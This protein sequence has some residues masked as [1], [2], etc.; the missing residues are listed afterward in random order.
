MQAYQRG[1]FIRQ[2][3]GDFLGQVYRPSEIHVWTGNDNRTVASAEAVLA[4]A[5]K[6]DA[7]H[8]WSNKLDWQPVAV[9]T[10]PTIDWV[11]TGING[12]CPEY[13]R[14]YFESPAYLEILAPFDPELIS[15]LENST[16]VSIESPIDF[17]HVIDSLMTKVGDVLFVRYIYSMSRPSLDFLEI[18]PQYSWIPTASE[19]FPQEIA[20]VLNHP[21]CPLQM[22]LNDK[23]LPYPK[24]AEP[25]RQNVSAIRTTFHQRMVDSQ[26]DTAGRYHLEMLLSFIEDHLNRPVDKKNKAVFVSGHDTNF[27]TIGRQLGD[28]TMA[29]EMVSYAALLAIELHLNNGTYYV[30]LWHAPSL[31]AELTRLNIPLCMNPCKLDTLQNALKDR[32]LT[33]TAWELECRGFGPQ[34]MDDSIITASMILLLAVFIISTV[35]L[36]CTTFSYRKQLKEL[37]DPERRRLL[38]E[39]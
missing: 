30:E 2:R 3:Y 23:A 5:F 28:S 20:N 27:L 33:R 37:Q 19:S 26:N 10:D 7:E 6:P 9:H 38:E 13:E 31:E 11:S 17:N 1:E 8:K 4:A 39:S 29:N 22:I 18:T 12:V 36:A 15:F 14:T 16:G 32:R 35:V 34:G 21:V 24:W 25:L